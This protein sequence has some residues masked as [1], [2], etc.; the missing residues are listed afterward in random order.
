MRDKV[1]KT[2]P[3]KN[4][5]AM[6]LKIIDSSNERRKLVI[7]VIT[8]ILDRLHKC[9]KQTKAVCSVVTFYNKRDR[10]GSEKIS[11]ILSFY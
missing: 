10:S 9:T 6:K 5:G 11:R 1:S 3:N 7:F 2:P 8:F 4:M